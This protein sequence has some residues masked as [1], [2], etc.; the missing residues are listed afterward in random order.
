VKSGAGLVADL[1]L[2]PFKYKKILFNHWGA[3][4]CHIP[5]WVLIPYTRALLLGARRLLLVDLS[6]ALGLSLVA[7]LWLLLL[8]R[9]RT[10]RARRLVMLRQ[11]A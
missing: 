1:C 7:L 2:M 3:S 6:L 10:R 11:L 4:I 9:R 5:V 8:E